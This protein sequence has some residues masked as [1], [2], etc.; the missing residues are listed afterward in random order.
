ME[1][2][3]QIIGSLVFPNKCILSFG[4]FNKN[5]ADLQSASSVTWAYNPP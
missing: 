5:E 3:L 4:M 2:N 1:D